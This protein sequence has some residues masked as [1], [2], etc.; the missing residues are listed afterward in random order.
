MTDRD[1]TAVDVGL[2]QVGAGVVSHVGAARV[3]VKR[4]GDS[5]CPTCTWLV[6]FDVVGRRDHFDH[7]LC[8]PVIAR[9]AVVVGSELPQGVAVDHG[10]PPI[11]ARVDYRPDRLGRP[12][13]PSGWRSR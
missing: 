13:S 4:R 9:F 7:G 5:T 6:F 12:G 8:S 1:G 3:L 10:V 11:Q 2:G